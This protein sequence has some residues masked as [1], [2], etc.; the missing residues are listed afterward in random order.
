MINSEIFHQIFHFPST[1]IFL[2]KI[3]FENFNIFQYYWKSSISLIQLLSNCPRYNGIQTL[4]YYVGWNWIAGNYSL[5]T[6]KFKCSDYH[7]QM[8]MTFP[9][10]TH[11]TTV[12][13][14][15]PQLWPPRSWMGEYKVLPKIAITVHWSFIFC[16]CENEASSIWAISR[17]TGFCSFLLGVDSNWVTKTKKKTKHFD[18]HHILNSILIES[19]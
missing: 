5:L 4:L 7:L 12:Q 11:D 6:G 16:P 17:N 3:I 15:G 8:N 14:C 2:K 9:H 10:R 19:Y 13:L 18:I 1:K